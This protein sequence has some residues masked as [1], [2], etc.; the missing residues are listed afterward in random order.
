MIHFL[1]I[2]EVAKVIF[3]NDVLR[4][5]PIEFIDTLGINVPDF[6]YGLPLLWFYPGGG[7]A[8]G[9]S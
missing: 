5:S 9:S 7:P 1:F 3:C 6:A 8:D 4:Y 2:W